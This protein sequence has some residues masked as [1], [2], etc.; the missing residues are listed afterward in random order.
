MKQLSVRAHAKIN[1]TL[2]VTGRREDGYHLVEMVM[3]SIGL[4]DVVTVQ[5]HT[6]SGEIQLHSSNDQ[7]PDD[8][9]NLCWRAAQLFLD[10][11]G[12]SNDGIAIRVEK[13][14]PMAA[15]LAG[16][17]TDAAAVLVL[18]DQ[19]YETRLTQDELCALGLRLGADVPF[20]MLGGTMLAQGI[21]E[22]LTRL[23]DAPD[24][25]VV[26]C[27]PPIGVSTPAV[28]K[29]IDAIEITKHPDTAAMLRAIQSGSVSEIAA[30]LV[31]VMQ[32]V[33]G[34]MHPEVL[35][36]R[37][38]MVDGGAL[39]AVM[40][41]SGPSVFG[42]FDDRQ[43]AQSVCDR[44]RDRYEHTFLTNFSPASLSEMR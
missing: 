11:T 29:A 12:V 43:A 19:L 38:A 32:P 30:Q 44:L 9:T 33:T 35:D 3:Q 5:A 15:G 28:Y 37:Q 14:I 4:H 18:L 1:L 39:G 23:P 26:L 7:L 34:G 24:P 20:C 22:Q 36:I 25:I 10:E 13:N 41:G 16:G 40:S 42:L 21:G 27:K 2:D 6:G 17:S 8:P 31:N